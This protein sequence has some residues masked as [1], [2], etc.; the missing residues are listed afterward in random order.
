MTLAASYAPSY[1]RSCIPAWARRVLAQDGDALLS[2]QDITACYQYLRSCRNVLDRS[3]RLLVRLDKQVPEAYHTVLNSMDYVFSVHGFGA[4]LDVS[5]IIHSL[6]KLGLGFGSS[7][8]ERKKA[9][10]LSVE[11]VEAFGDEKRC[12]NYMQLSAAKQR[13]SNWKYRLRVAVSEAVGAGWYPMFG[14]YTVDPSWLPN[15]CNGDRDRLWRESPAWDRFV[16]K[17]K[18]SVAISCGYGAKPCKWPRT[19]EFFQYFAVIEHGASGNHPHVHVVWLCKN[20]PALWKNDPNINNRDNSAR[21]MPSASALWP[22]GVQRKTCGLFVTGSWFKEN[23]KIPIDEKS[24]KPITIGDAGAVAGYV[25]KYLTKGETKKWNHRVKA[26][27]GLGLMSLTRS[28]RDIKS[29]KLLL[30]LSARP[31]R[32]NLAMEMQS[33]TLCPLNLLRKMSKEVL[34]KR[35]HSS[36]SLQAFE[37]IRKR[38]TKSRGGFFINLMRS[39]RA[40]HKPW[41]MTPG[42]RYSYFCPMLEE[43]SSTV[44]CKKNDD[45]RWLHILC[46]LDDNCGMEKSSEE[47]TYLRPEVSNG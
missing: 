12:R 44:H 33:R 27:R 14:T 31:P 7:Y 42:Q 46:W 13:A 21:D 8:V 40:G 30:G 28:L 1:Q 9:V 23:W 45:S 34:L 4:L 2:Y 39:V 22:H 18:R 10:G 26:T 17:F 20:I 16:K 15:W 29:L 35:L 47:Y 11:C 38:L 25:A 37:W 3:Y 19:M 6:E 5:K 32:Y 41:R 36:R 43:V 24:G